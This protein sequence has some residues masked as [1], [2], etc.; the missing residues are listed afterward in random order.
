MCHQTLQ[1][2]PQVQDENVGHKLWLKT[3]ET[4]WTIA[5]FRDEI[6][7]IHSFIQSFFDTLKGYGKRISEIKEAHVI[8]T[9]KA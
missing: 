3:L 9:Q 7:F 8:A 5:L 1:I 4:N 6:V 2:Q